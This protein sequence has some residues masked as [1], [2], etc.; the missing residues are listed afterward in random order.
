MR[1]CIVNDSFVEA[2]PPAPPLNRLLL[3][4]HAVTLTHLFE[5]NVSTHPFIEQRDECRVRVDRCTPCSGVV[6]DPL[7]N[8]FSSFRIRSHIIST[9]FYDG[10]ELYQLDVF[11]A[12]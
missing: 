5:I 12:N 2:H 8:C 10:G 11:N 1:K 4:E 9:A 6:D 3:E 7:G